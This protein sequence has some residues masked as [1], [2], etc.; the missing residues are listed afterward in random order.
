M[1]TFNAT[2]LD[3]LNKEEKITYIKTNLAHGENLFSKIPEELSEQE[4]HDSAIFTS[5]EEQA[6]LA[7]NNLISEVKIF[8]AEQA[9]KLPAELKKIGLNASEQKFVNDKFK[10]TIL[11]AASHASD[12]LIDNLSQKDGFLYNQVL[13]ETT[14][15]I[16]EKILEFKSN[17]D[18]RYPGMSDKI[19][20]QSTLGLTMALSAYSPPLSIALKTSGILDKISD[21]LQ[22]DN[23]QTTIDNMNESLEKIKQDKILGAIVEKT[24]KL[25]LVSDETSI[26][27]SSLIK[28]NINPD[29]AKLIAKN[30][31]QSEEI[32]EFTQE[33]TSYLDKNI[34][35]NTAE[36]NKKFQEFRKE[37]SAELSNSDL[38]DQLIQDF[39]KI[40]EKEIIKSQ[41]L[42]L[43]AIK[44]DAGPFD[45]IAL[46]HKSGDSLDKIKNKINFKLK[47]TYPD[48]ASKISKATRIIG[49]FSSN[50]KGDSTIINQKLKKNPKLNKFARENLN[51][52]VKNAIDMRPTRIK[53]G[54][55]TNKRSR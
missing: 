26:S 10:Q 7:L 13:S 53:L 20:K 48:H 42:S 27:V 9:T 38:P 40:L 24:E 19:I 23:L 54:P 11:V 5:Y 34:P 25:S 33:V 22:T 18:T 39:N 44:K 52:T 15:N 12:K 47:T 29:K 43:N 1:S 16:F 6:K 3:K 30:I 31:S 55:S 2:D 41:A 32:K 36:I 51:L 50:I 4:L 8:I 21:F 28:S 49:N 45:K 17:I 37:I 35:A 14:V 46:L